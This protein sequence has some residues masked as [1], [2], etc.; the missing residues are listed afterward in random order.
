MGDVG[1]EDGVYLILSTNDDFTDF[2]VDFFGSSSDTYIQTASELYN[3]KKQKTPI[4]IFLASSGDGGQNL[5]SPVFYSSNVSNQK[6]YTN[7]EII[8]LS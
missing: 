5:Y 6:T 3:Y 8:I 2:S 7:S 4:S 1:Y